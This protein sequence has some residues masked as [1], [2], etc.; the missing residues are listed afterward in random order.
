[1]RKQP[2]RDVLV[3]DSKDVEQRL[4]GAHTVLRATYAYAYQMH[5]SLGTSCA[6]ADVRKD[7]ATVWSPT[8][9][10]YPTR[11][12]VAKLVG[13]PLDSIR[14]IYMRGSGCYGLNGADAVSFDA[15][16]LSQAVGR[17]V[18][19]QLSREDEMAWENFGS[20]CVVEQRAAIDAGR[21]VA[22]D[23]ENWMASK[24]GRPGYDR[25]GN[26]ITGELLGYPA[27]AVTPRGAAEP[28]REL[29]NRSNDAPSYVAGCIGGK[30]GGA[31]TVRSER[32]LSHT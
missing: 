16:V 5:G 26:V 12:I 10:V 11:S 8:Q 17:P 29:R 31:G 27:E 13:L 14:V 20:A 4:A 6:V 1:M 7:G 18:R 32:V 30:C 2:S 23:C 25:P 19:V 3:V 9:S 24:G 15:A 21:I 28:T 22:W